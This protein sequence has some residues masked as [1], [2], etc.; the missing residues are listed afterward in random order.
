MTLK[1]KMWMYIAIVL[2]VAAAL[3]WSY[4]AFIQ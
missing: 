4:G 1:T 2:W 3:L